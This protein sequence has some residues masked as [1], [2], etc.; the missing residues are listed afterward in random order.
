MHP[1]AK[2]LLRDGQLCEVQVATTRFAPSADV[3]SHQTRVQSFY[4]LF[5][6]FLPPPPSPPS[7]LGSG[8]KGGRKGGGKEGEKEKEEEERRKEEGFNDLL[9]SV[10]VDKRVCILYLTPLAVERSERSELS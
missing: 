1:P 2:T 6:F 9:S 4:L 10:V 8:E 5:F 7:E 3:V